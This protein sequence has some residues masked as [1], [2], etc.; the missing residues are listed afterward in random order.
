MFSRLFLVALCLASSTSLRAVA[1]SGPPDLSSQIDALFEGIVR[2]NTPGAAVFIA[3]DGKKLL[4]KGYGL[5]QVETHTPITCDT[6]FRIGSITKQF[7]AAAI[8]KLQ[9]QGRLNVNDPISK[10]FPDWPRGREVTLRHLLTHSSGIH[11]FTAKPGFQTNVTI[12]MPLEALISSFKND[13]YD[14]IPG[15]KFRYS[16]SGYVLLGAIIEKVSGGTYA[17]YLRNT[18]FE[19]LGMKN[20][21]VYPSGALLTN[22][23]LGYAY[24]NGPVRR[25]VDWNMSNVAAAG[26]LYS[27]ARDLFLWNEALFGGRVLSP[28]SLR[29][30]FTVGVLAGDDP[31]HPEDTGYGYGWTIDRLNGAREISHGGEL[32]GFGSYLLRL[33]EY[34]LTVVVMLNCVPQ[35]PKL[36]QWILAREIACLAL[37]PE[38]PPHAEPKAATNVPAA[39][40][41]AIIGRYD[42]SDGTTLTITRENGRVFMEIT[43]R[44]KFEILPK[45]DRTFFVNSGEAEATFVR[46]ANGQVVKVILKQG[47]ER[48]DAPKLNN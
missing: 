45:S 7:T 47:G 24:E 39:A 30:A 36:Q 28:A 38:L 16:N 11:N 37:G 41:D 3:R 5:A 12:A 9:E 44:K 35:L 21:G 40:L 42:M 18:F 29:A 32:A 19:P 6:R 17:S 46:N 33:P 48:I 1:A 23:A 14:F 27:T 43:G 4:E 34:K 13:P 22:E 2:S 26:N 20:T 25:S 31:R 10:Y 15:E 8:L